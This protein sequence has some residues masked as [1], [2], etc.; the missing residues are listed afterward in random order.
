MNDFREKYPHVRVIGF[1]G[2]ARA[3]KTTA[4]RLLREDMRITG[5]QTAKHPL[6]F[7]E[8]LS[9]AKPLRMICKSVFPYVD[10]KYFDEQEFKEVQIPGLPE[11]VTGRKIM[12]H[13]GTEGFRWLVPDAWVR[14]AESM[15][16]SAAADGAAL[17]T[18]DDVRFFD[19]AALIRRYGQLYRIE[20]PGCET[21]EHSSE[22]YARDLPV[23]GVI[24][25]DATIAKLAARLAAA[26]K[27]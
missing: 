17:I 10:E 25:N 24:E 18:F 12:V 2:F 22:L 20:R 19:E 15:I 7:A 5:L 8:A 3:G 13:I 27:E 14:L 9:F 11:G 4:A 23:D 16:L 26:L 6:L 1:T 21:G